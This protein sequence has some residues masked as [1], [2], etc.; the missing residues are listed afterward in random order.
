MPSQQEILRLPPPGSHPVLIARKL[1][2]LGS[3]LQSIPSGAVKHPGRLDVKYREVMSHAV[4][5]A[6]RLV[7]SN[8]DLVGSLEGIECI[9][10][11]SMYQNNAGNLRRA[12][13]TNRRAMAIAQMMGLH[14]GNPPAVNMLDIETQERID[15]EYMWLRLVMSD[16]Y[17][18]LMLG[19][20]PGSQESPF[21]TPNAL[22][23]CAP[24]ERMERIDVVVGGLILQR[25]R[26]NLHNLEATYEIDKLLQDAAASMPPEWWLTPDANTIAGFNADAYSESIRITLQFAHFHLLAHLHL[27]YMLRPSADRKYDYSKITAVNASREILSR[28][29]CFRGSNTTPAYC[30]GI[31]FLALIASTTMCLAHIDARGQYGID[32]S[33]CM[34]VFHFLAHQRLG[35]RGLMERTLQIME[36]MVQAN[37]DAIACKI[38]SILR[39]LLTIEAAAAKG[40]YYNASVSSQSGE[41]DLMSCGNGNDGVD[42]L[43]VNIPHF[44]T[45]KIEHGG[46][47]RYGELVHGP[48]EEHARPRSVSKASHSGIGYCV[49]LRSPPNCAGQER[50]REDTPSTASFAGHQ[51]GNQSVHAD[52]QAVPSNLDFMRS[53]EESQAT[54]SDQGFLDLNDCPLDAERPIVPGLSAEEDD[55]ILQGVDLALYDSLFEG[56][57]TEP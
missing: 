2:L 1:L 13:L 47:L 24:M 53:A 16:R 34:T 28:F 10:I 8:D 38:A 56:W 6:S 9:M 20:P 19:L 48:C 54:T 50:R 39:R 55:W 33:N 5:T 15:P 31:D 46:G 22:K 40:S 49:E 42:T 26:E 29:V 12:W 11:E 44:G 7:T 52:W 3:F 41:Q 57:G 4:E 32:T 27:P 35:D 21:A 45:V 14:L 30:R 36:K 23:G 17:L 18:S 37:G 25:N 51:I 43:C